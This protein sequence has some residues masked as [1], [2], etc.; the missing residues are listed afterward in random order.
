ME[1]ACRKGDLE[2][3]KDLVRANKRLVTSADS[4]GIT[5]LHRAS[6]GNH[7]ELVR[8]LL[9][10][11]ADINAVDKYS[12]TALKKAAYGGHVNVVNELVLCKADVNI[13]DQSGKLPLHHAAEQGQLQSTELLLDARF[14]TCDCTRLCC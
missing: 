2:S 12:D 4:I 11:R 8:F 10:Q 1:D 3:V 14:L 9:F 13:P 6:A 7:L 5:P